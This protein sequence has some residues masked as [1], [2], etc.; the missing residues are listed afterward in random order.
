[1]LR[2]FGTC[3]CGY[4]LP[5]EEHIRSVCPICGALLEIRYEGGDEVEDSCEHEPDWG[6]V[7]Y[8]EINEDGK[9]EMETYCIHCGAGLIVSLMIK[10]AMESYNIEDVQLRE[11]DTYE[12]DQ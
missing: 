6:E 3:K 8:P 9:L 7:D 2:R 10:D 11:E 1:M 4:V 5:E 12:E